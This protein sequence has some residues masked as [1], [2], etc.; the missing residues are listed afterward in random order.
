MWWLSWRPP[1]A[2]RGMREREGAKGQPAKHL[3][4][5]PR[6]RRFAGQAGEAPATAL[7]G[8][9]GWPASVTCEPFCGGQGDSYVNPP[10]RLFCSP[11]EP[12]L[13]HS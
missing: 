3:G 8:M 1:F 5:R 9:R 12:I 10:V 7:T 6:Q 13:T 11:I 2:P 4:H